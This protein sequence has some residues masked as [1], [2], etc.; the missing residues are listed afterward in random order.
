MQ[1]FLTW[2]G[3]GWPRQQ[4]VPWSES[5]MPRRLN[6]FISVPCAPKII[7]WFLVE[8]LIWMLNVSLGLRAIIFWNLLPVEPH[9]SLDTPT[10]PSFSILS[11][12]IYYTSLSILSYDVDSFPIWGR[13]AQILW[14]RKNRLSPST[15][16]KANVKKKLFLP[17]ALLGDSPPI[18]PIVC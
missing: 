4:A 11:S 18:C 16:T 2:M 6:Q 9:Y 10:Y 7:W 15:N 13:K 12:V 17:K 5:V 14:I 3:F 8:P 1:R